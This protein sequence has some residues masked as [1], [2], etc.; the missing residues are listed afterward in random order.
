MLSILNPRLLISPDILQSTPG[1]FDT[2]KDMIL[3]RINTPSDF[4]AIY[5]K[6]AC[7]SN[8]PKRRSYKN[9]AVPLT[10]PFYRPLQALNQALNL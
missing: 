2:M 6:T 10:L 5:K 4:I 3:C 9:F 8:K 1:W 7:S